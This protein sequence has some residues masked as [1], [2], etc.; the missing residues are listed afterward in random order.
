MES[1]A[2][3][4]ILDNDGKF[5]LFSQLTFAEQLCFI[6]ILFVID[7][8][9]DSDYERFAA[10][11]KLEDIKFLFLGPYLLDEKQRTKAQR[12]LRAYILSCLNKRRQNVVYLLLNNQADQG[13]EEPHYFQ[14]VAVRL[15]SYLL[16]AEKYGELKLMV[17]FLRVVRNHNPA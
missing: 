3:Y 10:L 4:E 15:A 6:S 14:H 11:S 2:K 8:E 13:L 17:E 9:T 7:D 16:S 12:G 5:P 1:F